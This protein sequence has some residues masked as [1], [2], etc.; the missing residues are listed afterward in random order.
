VAVL[1]PADVFA[2]VHSWPE[3]TFGLAMPKTGC[4]V[5]AVVDWETGIENGTLRV[6]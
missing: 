3:G 6:V 4:P 2:G 5:G 1:V